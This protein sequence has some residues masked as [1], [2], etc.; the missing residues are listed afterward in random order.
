MPR[1]SRPID[2][3]LIYHVINRGNQRWGVFH[4]VADFRPFLPALGEL[5]RRKPFEPYGYR[6]LTNQFPLLLCRRGDATIS[7]IL[8]SL[9]I[10]PL[11]H[12]HRHYGSGG[13]VWQGRLK[14]PG[15]PE[16]RAFAESAA[17]GGGQPPTVRMGEAGRRLPVAQLPSTRPKRAARFADRLRIALAVGRG[18]AAQ[19]GTVGASAH[20]RGSAG[21]QPPL[22][23]YRSA[24][25]RCNVGQ[26]FGKVVGEVPDHS[27]PQ[28]TEKDPSLP[29]KLAAR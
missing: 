29:H 25:W 26:T 6:L 20:R 15:D 12:S 8:Q 17:V 11:A 5:R 2:D 10:S 9:L 3:G 21:S 22:H 13:H 14:K 27:S 18:A 16:R 28:S 1:P 4:K 19:M 24:L 7:R 23:G